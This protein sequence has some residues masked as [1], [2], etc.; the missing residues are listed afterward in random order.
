MN[1]CSIISVQEGVQM[2]T[3]DCP[4]C[5]KVLTYSSERSVKAAI[6]KKT[7]CKSCCKTG[8]LRSIETRKSISEGRKGMT[9]SEEHKR[10]LSEAH[11]GIEYGPHSDET[12]IKMSIASGGTGDIEKLND[13]ARRQPG[14][15]RRLRKECLERDNHACVYC[16]KHDGE[17]HAHHILS[18]A[19]HEAH[20]YFLNNLI[21]LCK[22]CHIEEHRIN[23]NI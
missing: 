11:K 23:G 5:G 8:R 16:G 12:R 20:R 14:P 22:P 1:N 17:L 9:F 7:R 18:W 15:L 3:R 19:R 2:H 4:D 6:R 21:T 13:P 10:N